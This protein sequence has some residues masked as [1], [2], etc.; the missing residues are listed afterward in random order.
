VE[1]TVCGYFRSAPK[2]RFGDIQCALTGDHLQQAILPLRSVDVFTDLYALLTLRAGIH[3]TLD[4][5]RLQAHGTGMFTGLVTVRTGSRV[6]AIKANHKRPAVAH[7]DQALEQAN[8]T[9]ETAEQM[10]RQGE[11]NGQQ[12]RGHSN[13]DELASGQF[14]P[15]QATPDL[16]RR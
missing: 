6:L 13:K 9:P 15:E 11:L 5:M 3:L 1:K 12:D 4:P 14:T 2:I 8:S 10:P 16:E 7:P